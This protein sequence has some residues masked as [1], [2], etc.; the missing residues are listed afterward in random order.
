MLCE[1]ARCGISGEEAKLLCSRA[2]DELGLRDEVDT[3]FES[4]CG[5]GAVGVVEGDL[6]RVLEE[7]K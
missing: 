3:D 4:R 5:N 6:L 2:R 7:G 1:G